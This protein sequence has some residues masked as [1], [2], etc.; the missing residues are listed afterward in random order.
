MFFYS[1]DLYTAH[2]LFLILLP[3]H[4]SL[5]ILLFICSNAGDSW[6]DEGQH[7]RGLSKDTT[8]EED[9]AIHLLSYL[10]CFEFY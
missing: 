1:T 5:K 4:D 2:Y 3:D 10:I 8:K 6:E 7:K 9:G